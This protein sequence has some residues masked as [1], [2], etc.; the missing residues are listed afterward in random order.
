[1]MENS[2]MEHEEWKFEACFELSDQ[3]VPLVSFSFLNTKIMAIFENFEVRE[4]DLRTKEISKSYNLQEIEGFELD[5]EIENPKVRAF[6]L[7]K[8]VQLIAIAD[9]KFV[10]IFEYSEDDPLSLTC[11]FEM[12]WIL[13]MEFA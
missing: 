11:R 9:D 5:E 7:E 13:Q 10:H 8:D 2:A 4:I 1:M 3:I 12:A 6:A